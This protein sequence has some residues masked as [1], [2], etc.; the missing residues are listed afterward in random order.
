MQPMVRK[1]YNN[2][3]FFLCLLI[4][5]VFSESVFLQFSFV[6]LFFAI[7]D[8][9]GVGEVFVDD[10]SIVSSNR[11]R[12]SLDRV[13]AV[14]YEGVFYKVLVVRTV[15][16]SYDVANNWRYRS[17]DILLLHDYIL[18]FLLRA[19]TCK[20]RSSQLPEN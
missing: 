4:L 5:G 15:N 10:G 9:L 6:F 3:A 14:E 19:E 13:V 16:K 8:F 17:S 12:I 18:D 2:I 7:F 1:S 20:F 11:I